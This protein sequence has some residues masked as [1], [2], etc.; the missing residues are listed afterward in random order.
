MYRIKWRGVAKNQLERD[1]VV[2]IINDENEKTLLEKEARIMQKFEQDKDSHIPKYYGCFIDKKNQYYLVFQYLSFSIK[3]NYS[4]SITV[5]NTKYRRFAKAS[6]A[7]RFNVYAQ[8]AM[9]LHQLH[10]K[11]IAHG[12]FKPDNMLLNEESGKFAAYVIDFGGAAESKVRP[13]AFTYAYL[14]EDFVKHY[15]KHNDVDLPEKDMAQYLNGPKLDV[16][17]LAITIYVLE[18]SYDP[19]N[20]S[21]VSPGDSFVKKPAFS[22]QFL[23]SINSLVTKEDWI[24]KRFDYYS[25]ETR[26]SLHDLIKRMMEVEPNNRPNAKTVAEDLKILS[27]KFYQDLLDMQTIKPYVYPTGIREARS[28]NKYDNPITKKQSPRPEDLSKGRGLMLSPTFKV[29]QNHRSPYHEGNTAKKERLPYLSP[30]NLEDLQ[31]PSGIPKYGLE[32][33]NSPGKLNVVFQK[34]PTNENGNKNSKKVQEGKKSESP[35]KG[36]SQC[37]GC[38]GAK[39][40]KVVGQRII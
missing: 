29:K 4:S 1:V 7:D 32:E 28:I 17:A 9:G 19:Q 3:P 38:F 23:R 24:K 34:S 5:K 8:L 2:K 25:Y 11:G 30:V 36:Y 37:F 15:F 12:D 27:D 16:Y 31:S 26:Q 39:G 13:Q 6:A 33:V 20:D 10:E 22:Y 18:N 14:D 21:V 40:R 35:F